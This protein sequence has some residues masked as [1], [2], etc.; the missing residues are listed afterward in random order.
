MRDSENEG[1]VSE[2]LMGTHK[3]DKAYYRGFIIYFIYLYDVYCDSPYIVKC[4]RSLNKFY[5]FI[6]QQY[7]KGYKKGL[8]DHY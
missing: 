4:I 1:N 6:F 7:F 3:F 5:I 8:Y 2:R